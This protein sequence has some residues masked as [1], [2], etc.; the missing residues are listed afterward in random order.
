MPG[1]VRDVLCARDRPG[2]DVHAGPA[3]PRQ[4]LRSQPSPSGN[5][6]SIFQRMARSNTTPRICG[7]QRWRLAEARCAMPMRAATDIAAIGITNQRET[8][9]L[10]HRA[11]GR[12]LHRAIVWQDR[13][14]ADL[15]AQLQGRR[16]RTDLR[17]QNRTFARSVFFRHQARLAARAHAGL[18]RCGRTRRT[19]F[20]H[21]RYVSA[22]AAHRRQGPRHRRHQR[23]AHAV[24]QYPQRPL[25]RRASGAARRAQER[26]AAGARFLR[27]LRHDRPGRCLAQPFRS[28]ASPAISRRR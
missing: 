20:R 27:R 24:V 7:R 25:G 12:P 16:P 23:V 9:L 22:V 11:T 28:A 21:G 10:W 3:I 14:T 15:C 19:R 6:H 2:D 8:T 18:S 4:T 17:S 26:V 1:G 5:S 13:R